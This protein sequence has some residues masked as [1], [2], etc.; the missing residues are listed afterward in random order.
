MTKHPTSNG[1]IPGNFYKRE[2][3]VIMVEIKPGVYVNQV[4]AFTRHGISPKKAK[5]GDHH[6]PTQGT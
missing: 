6:G 5:R 2:D 3:D 4:T 1:F